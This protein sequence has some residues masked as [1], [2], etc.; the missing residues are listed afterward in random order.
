MTFI[1]RPL[2]VFSLAEAKLDL[3]YH[4]VGGIRA[5]LRRGKVVGRW[6]GTPE[7][8]H[9]FLSESVLLDDDFQQIP[10]RLD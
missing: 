8:A 3:C 1:F 9:I 6:T 10:D 5:N 7:N 2:L 4:I